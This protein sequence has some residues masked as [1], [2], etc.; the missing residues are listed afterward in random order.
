[1]RPYAAYTKPLSLSRQ[2]KNPDLIIRVKVLTEDEGGRK[3]PFFNGYRGQFYYNNSDWDATYDIIEK[4]EAKP[5]EEVELELIT[6]GREIHFGKFEIGKEVKIREGSKV[7][8]KGNVIRVLNKKFE[9]WDLEKFQSSIT[10]QYIPY[11]GDLIEGYKRFFKY[12]L[13]DEDLFKGIEII[14]LTHPT[15]ILTVKL[16]KKE[17][18]F[19]TVYQFITKQWRENL[20]LENDRLK[21][22]YKLNNSMKLEKIKM[23]FATWGKIEKLYITGEIIIE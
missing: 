6:A 22:D 20:K 1:M 23:Q 14:E 3:T 2:M 15:K 8:A 17:N 10:E 9:K 7:V 18:T 11:S 13:L 19:S 21:I 4:S 12:Y 5:G 16:N